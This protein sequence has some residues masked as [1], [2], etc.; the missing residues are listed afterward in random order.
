LNDVGAAIRRALGEENYVW[1][2][3]EKCI[4]FNCK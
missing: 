2:G 4:E 1:V 3:L